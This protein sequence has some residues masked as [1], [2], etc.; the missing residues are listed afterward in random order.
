MVFDLTEQSEMVDALHHSETLYDTF[1]EQSPVGLVHLDATGTV[2]F[3]NFRFRQIV[4]EDPDD[5]WIG[6]SAFTIPGTGGVF[7]S[8]LKRLLSGQQVT[9]FD[10]R[11][12]PPGRA[13][14]RLLLN[15][16]P[17]RQ[18]DG[19]V[20][21]AVL[22]F[23]DVTQER[24]QAEEV[25]LRER[26]TRAE[27]AL[28]EAVFAHESEAAFLR[29]AARLIGAATETQRVALFLPS[30][31]HVGAFV[32]RV[33][34]GDAPEA[35]DRRTLTAHHPEAEL[36]I[37]QRAPLMLP[38]MMP[39]S[40]AP[41]GPLPAREALLA[42]FFERDGLQG[43]VVAERTEP[44]EPLLGGLR[45]RLITDLVRVFETLL[46]WLRSTERFRLTVS[47]IEDGLFN[48]VLDA[49]GYRHYLFLTPQVQHLT[50]QHAEAFLEAP[51]LWEGL[52]DDPESR[53]ALAAHADRLLQGKQSEVTYTLDALDG[54]TRTVRERATPFRGDDGTLSVTGIFSDV[55]AQEQARAVLVNAKLAAEQAN[56]DK[57]AFIQTLSH[58]MRTPLGAI[59]GFAELLEHELDE[60]P[61]APSPQILE[62]VA[63]IR[64]RA[65]ATLALVND[66]FELT[67]FDSGAVEVKRVAVPLD[68]AAERVA[69]ATVQKAREGVE[70]R[71]DLQP[72]TAVADPARLDQVIQ[73]LLSNAF[74]FTHAGRVT[75]TTRREGAQAILEVRD[76][77]I[78]ISEVYMQRLFTPF[79]QED[80]RLNREY[81]GTGL[82]LALVKRLV[83]FM[84]GTVEATSAKGAGTTFRVL[85]P[86]AEA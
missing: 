66:L 5:A 28:R 8:A 73:N 79:E 86:A 32:P 56:R 1:L 75:V 78:G 60:L 29:E 31:E 83:D 62:F 43:F 15:G 59:S 38:V 69:A 37:A 44:G 2:T 18:E 81:E 20:V 36:A 71:L 9:G 12:A 21:G 85:L 47:T 34:W 6:R 40:T 35:F 74:K 39:V 30:G 53:A 58:E 82:G 61:G 14:N 25:A 70:L 10:V 55:T 68:V 23:Q 42:P 24:A 22:M 63:T 45:L 52:V 67:S 27:S 50:G 57:T 76:T 13:P 46:S 3:E 77:G 33:R 41:G 17:I 51:G 49:H 19:N 48:Y 54:A 80:Q 4:G 64:E 7:S 72:V 11:F 65:R 26:F 16:A 84:G